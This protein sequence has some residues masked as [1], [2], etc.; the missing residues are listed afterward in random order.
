M[1]QLDH[2]QKL[3]LRVNQY[4]CCWTLSALCPAKE[5]RGATQC[6]IFCRHHP[7]LTFPFI[8]M[9]QQY[10]RVYISISPHHTKGCP[11][12]Y[13]PILSFGHPYPS[14]SSSS[15]SMWIPLIPLTYHVFPSS[16]LNSQSISPQLKSLAITTSLQLSVTSL[17]LSR[18]SWLLHNF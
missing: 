5:N 6:A 11:W 10:Y 12:L 18:V 17:M 4:S 1:M 7:G 8:E 14:M 15:C 3:P 13:T 16:A 2:Y 9:F